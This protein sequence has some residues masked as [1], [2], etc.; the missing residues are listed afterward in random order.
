MSSLTSASLQCPCKTFMQALQN[1]AGPRVNGS[2]VRGA[3]C[4]VSKSMDLFDTVLQVQVPTMHFTL[5]EMTKRN[6]NKR[7]KA[8]GKA[9]SKIT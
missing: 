3:R 1:W 6:F 4:L 5:K 7:L 2:Q 9:K 8:T